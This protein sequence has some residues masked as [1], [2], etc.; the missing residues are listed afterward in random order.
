MKKLAFGALVVGLVACGGGK[1][2][3]GVVVVDSGGD[4]GGTGA[5]NVLT[6]TGCNTGE[7]CTWIIDAT[8][9]QEIGHIGCAP[10]GTKPAGDKTCMYGAPG[11]TGYDDCVQGAVC[12]GGVTGAGLC[13]SICDQQGG[14]PMCGTGF[15]C[16]VYEGFLGP[17]GMEA[18]GV[19]DPTCDPLADNLFGKATKP[20]TAC[21]MTEGCYPQFSNAAPRRSSASCARVPT[22]SATLFNLSQCTTANGCANAGGTPYLNGCAQGFRA[23]ITDDTTGSNTFACRSLCA[24]V[25][26]FQG[27]CTGAN[28]PDNHLGK[29]GHACNVNDSSGTFNP[30]GN[31]DHCVAAW[32]FE[33]ASDGMS[34]QKS[35]FSD[36]LGICLDHGSFHWDSN[37]NGMIDAA[38]L[39]WGVPV[40]N[41]APNQIGCI[42][43]PKTSATAGAGA[44]FFFCVTATTAGITQNFKRPTTLIE[45]PRLPYTN[46]LSRAQ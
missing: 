9:P 19:C 30:T 5:C 22:N 12:F 4:D 40:P 24:M 29:M 15:A 38:D 18:G 27:S 28:N 8:T 16:Q 3:T 43:L 10:N 37:N 33:T 46:V 25:D 17:A 34:I 36:T 21:A 41:A 1:N 44:D 11:A 7:K 2:N 23:L 39:N 32:L 6:Q 45:K 20:G 31:R 26:C 35:P 42:N 14:A 13:K